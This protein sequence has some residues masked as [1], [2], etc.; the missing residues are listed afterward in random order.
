MD[1]PRRHPRRA[2]TGREAVRLYDC[3]IARG[4]SFGSS[5]TNW[6]PHFPAFPNFMFPRYE[7]HRWNLARMSQPPALTDP[8]GTQRAEAHDRSDDGDGHHTGRWIQSGL[9]RRKGYRAH[10]RCGSAFPRKA[11]ARS[12]CS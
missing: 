4:I 8:R 1:R 10:V 3:L 9:G 11:S 7:V 12:A 5:G 2:S 6:R